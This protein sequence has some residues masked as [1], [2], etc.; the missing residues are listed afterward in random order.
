MKNAIVH[1]CE[2]RYIV[3]DIT[4]DRT[5]LKLREILGKSS[6]CTSEFMSLIALEKRVRK[7]AHNS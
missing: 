7:N 4:K 6:I 2:R 5:A 3:L 1:H